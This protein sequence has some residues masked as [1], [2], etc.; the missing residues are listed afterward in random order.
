MRKL[1]IVICFIATSLGLYS[2]PNNPDKFPFSYGRYIV[3]TLS[4]ERFRG[5]GYIKEGENKAAYFIASEFMRMGLKQFTGAR[6]YYQNFTMSVNTFPRDVFLAVD[7][8]YL[9][10]G[11]DFVPR[12]NCPDIKG[13]WNVVWLDSNTVASN[14]EYKK[15]ARRD[16]SDHFIVIDDKGVTDEDQKNIFKNMAK[17][18][19]G[20]RGLI[21]I[22]EKITW[23]VAT[24]VGSYPV[25]EIVRG[26]IDK[27]AEKVRVNVDSKYYDEYHARNVI[28]Y[29]EGKV[30]P[31]SFI[32]VSGHYDHLGQ[33]GRNVF[34]P[35][36]NDNASGIGM[37]LSLAKWY[38]QPENQPDYSIAFVG[39]GAEEAGLIGSVKYVRYP[40]F[41][42][43]KIRF[44][45]NVDIMGTG[46]EGITVVNATEFK[47]EF[48][49]L[50]G[51][52]DDKNY[53]VTIRQR[54][55]AAN[56]DH[57][58]F[59][60]NDVRCFFAYTMGA[61]KFYHDIDDRGETLPLNEFEDMHFLFREFIDQLQ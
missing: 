35:G 30:Q 53:L 7:N 59:F 40:V 26:N 19:F 3:D 33:L 36:A 43:D 14:D 15:F 24:S 21:Y 54:G 2:Q 29:I 18:P 42:L 16:F 47:E 8:N 60:Q 25:F 27:G 22:R 11:R 49:L 28:G 41:P 13:T 48:N 10:A 56:S 58:P 5:R 38:S 37:M 20:A 4:S 12:P 51:I 9:R 45:L 32:V 61:V 6:N 23:G 52:N 57:Y 44:L 55:P 1:F 17:N 34:F 39:F 46:E 31:D 50:N